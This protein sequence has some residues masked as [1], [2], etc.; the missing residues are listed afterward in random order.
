MTQPRYE[1]TDFEWRIIRPLLPN[2][3]RG[4]PRVV[5]RK[6]LNGIYWRLRSGS[7]WANIPDH[8]GSYMTCYHRFIPWR[9]IGV[10]ETIFEAISKAYDDDRQMANPSSSIRG[11]N[12]ADSIQE[13]RRKSPP[14]GLSLQPNVW[15]VECWR[16]QLLTKWSS[17]PPLHSV[18]AKPDTAWR[19]RL[20][21]R[22]SAPRTGTV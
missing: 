4:V 17:D 20:Q 7:P 13:T 1:L 21:Q 16:N 19:L 2:K 11:R 18:T 15:G 10:W 6:V 8:Y 14:Q 3:P 9:K 5:D 12:G 22:L